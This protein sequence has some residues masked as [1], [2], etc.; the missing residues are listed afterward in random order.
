MNTSAEI[1]LDL[2]SVDDML[3]KKTGPLN[4]RRILNDATEEFIVEEASKLPRSKP[5]SFTVRVPL[6]ETKRA[7]EIVFAIHKHFAYCRRKSKAKVKNTLLTGWRSLAI[8][9]VFLLLAYF[10]VE[11]LRPYFSEGSLAI[12]V[13]ELLIILAWVALWRPA[14]LLLYDWYPFLKD[15]TLFRRLEQSTV[16]VTDNVTKN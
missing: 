2:Q 12:T 16:E 5:F 8:G 13:R 4:C 9:F 15:T 11:V 1:I 6:H 10:L 14:E 3:L 7:N